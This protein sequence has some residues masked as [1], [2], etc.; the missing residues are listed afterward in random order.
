MT[1]SLQNKVGPYTLQKLLATGSQSQVWLASGP[2]GD[3][4]VKVARTP[5]H[6]D[7]LRREAK[8]LSLGEHPGLPKLLEL[9][10]DGTWLAI[11][12]IDGAQIDQ[13]AQVQD[14][15]EVVRATHE[16][17]DVLDWLHQHD[18]THGD[19]KPSNV[20]ID[21]GGHLKLIDLGVAEFGN[22]DGGGDGTFRG[23]LGYAAP[24]RLR[25]RACTPAAD[26]YSVGALLY[27][28][29]T[30]RPPFVAAD[31]A[32]LTYLPLVSLPPPPCSLAPE[33]PAAMNN[34][35]LSL[36]CREPQT[37]LGTTADVRLALNNVEGSLA[38]PPVLGMHHERELLRRA[39]VGTADGEPRVVMLY[40]PPGSGRRTLIRETIEAAV[41]AGLNY[42]KGSDLRGVLKA[43]KSKT[44]PM[45]AVMRNTRNAQKLASLALKDDMR[46]LLLL[47]SDRP[48]PSLEAEGAI[49]LTPAPLS[50][51]DV[52]RLARFHGADEAE[53]SAWWQNS[54][55]LPAVILAHIRAWRREHMGD[56]FDPDALTAEARGILEAIGD[57][58]VDVPDLAKRAN[59]T[60]MELLDHCEAIF[61]EG[62]IAPER[63]GN[64][65]SRTGVGG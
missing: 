59:M 39:V 62:L 17:L 21:R 42:H 5:A 50:A 28:C 44:G 34:L 41:R 15:G 26:L 56:A 19:I 6:A 13:W 45:V 51:L 40:G 32:A 60:E 22:K 12:R 37:R 3:V 25:G 55:G 31:P 63:D 52:T 11:E 58:T 8:V 46:C 16:L 27:T 4:A 29:L 30:G 65:I 36:L 23:T 33:L 14:L 35:L 7:A 2:K 20:L 49:Q 48:V 18:I 38:R 64:A 54:L 47:H 1:D 61:A 43:M 10:D 53:T 57:D 24:E 9:A